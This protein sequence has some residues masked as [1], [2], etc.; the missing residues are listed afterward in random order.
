MTIFGLFSIIKFTTIDKYLN[1]DKIV[2]AKTGLTGPPVASAEQAA[3]I[4][5]E[6]QDRAR[7]RIQQELRAEVKGIA[8]TVV[9]TLVWAYGSYVPIFKFPLK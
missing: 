1:Q 4:R 6:T 8:L 2:G 9:G 5:R 3:Q 7:T